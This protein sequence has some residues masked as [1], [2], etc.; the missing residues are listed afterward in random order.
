MLIPG[1]ST[2]DKLVL[3]LEQLQLDE[4]RYTLLDMIHICVESF[5]KGREPQ[6]ALDD[7]RVLFADEP[8]ESLQIAREEMT[9]EMPVS[10]LKK[11]RNPIDPIGAGDDAETAQ[12]LDERHRNAVDGDR[13]ASLDRDLDRSRFFRT[14]MHRTAV[15][16]LDVGSSNDS[17]AVRVGGLL[18]ATHLS[19]AERRQNRKCAVERVQ[20]LVVIRT[21]RGQA[22]ALAEAM[23][24]A[25]L[26]EVVGT[27]GGDDTILVIA[28]DSRRATALVKRLETYAAR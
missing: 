3:A 9:F 14:R 1:P 24:R 26:P 12:Q 23:D 4:A 21:G 18:R 8:R 16:S 20:Q 10:G 7:G 28:R 6:A 5:T 11:E 22:Q 19:V 25:Q 13:H 27:I 17:L 2:I 15:V